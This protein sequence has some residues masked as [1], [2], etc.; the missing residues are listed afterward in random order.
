MT[1]LDRRRPPSIAPRSSGSRPSTSR[2]AVPRP[3]SSSP[4]AERADRADEASPAL[5]GKQ[6]RGGR[7]PEREADA[8]QPAPAKKPAPATK[9]APPKKPAAAKQQAADRKPH[10]QTPARGAAPATVDS[11]EAAALSP[12]APTRRAIPDPD[13]PS[14]WQA[15]TV[16]DVSDRVKQRDDERRRAALLVATRRWGLRLLVVG[17]VAGLAW[18]GL[19]SPWF[20]LDEE[21]I[22]ITGVSQLTDAEEVDAIVAEY[23]GTPLAAVGIR[24][25]TSQLE[26][27]PSVHD[28]TVTRVWPDGLAV[29]VDEAIPVAA[30]RVDEGFQLLD[31][32]GAVITV[33]EA[34]PDV[35]VIQIPTGEG[36]ARILDAVLTVLDA[37]PEEIRA[38]MT[39]MQASTEDS[40]HLTLADGP[41]VEWGS[42]EESDLKAEVLTLLLSQ[43]AG[44]NADVIDVSAP[45]LPITRSN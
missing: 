42:A 21:H 34:A 39:S 11:T 24:S 13:V 3:P 38:T 36:S 12:G 20:A 22:E 45:T 14:P 33:A 40:V 10:A 15:A 37:V 29:E 31:D 19:A 7:K 28:A 27:M 17:A 2:P 30:V 35:P 16:T 41:D 26:A 23:I 25:I 1:D 5:A 4:R 8:K 44:K 43:P 6:A 32:S 9:A 18:L